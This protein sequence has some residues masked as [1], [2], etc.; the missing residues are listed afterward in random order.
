M[1]GRTRDHL[2]ARTHEQGPHKGADFSIISYLPNF[3]FHLTAAYAIAL[4]C[5]VELGKRDFL[6]A[7]SLSSKLIGVEVV[8]L[9]D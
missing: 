5:G 8:R 1:A 6:G 2:P 4:G 7:I 9:A 3:Y